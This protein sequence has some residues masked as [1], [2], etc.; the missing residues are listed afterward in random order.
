M[1]WI[2]L[3]WMA[4]IS[5]GVCSVPA[6]GQALPDPTDV[7]PSV[8]LPVVVSHPS[9]EF[10]VG[11]HDFGK[12]SDDDKVT[13]VFPFTNLGGETLIITNVRT[14]CGCTVP[15]LTQKEYAPGQ[16][17]QITVTFNPAG[18]RGQNIKAIHV[19][20]NDPE[21]PV[22]K[23]EISALVEPRIWMEP[24]A[25]QFMQMTKG[26]KAAQQA[27]IYSVDPT[28]KVDFMTTSAPDVLAAK[29]LDRGTTNLRGRK[30][31][32]T[33]VEVELLGATKIGRTH[34]V[35]TIRT[36]DKKK[37]RISLNVMLDVVGDL[38]IRPS[39]VWIGMLHPGDSFEKE[40][41]LSSRSG[42]PFKI[43]TDSIECTGD[44]QIEARI[45]P[46]ETNTP[47]VKAGQDATIQPAGTKRLFGYRIRL[48][49]VAPERVLPMVGT[50][51]LKTDSPDQP[52]FDVPFR[53]TMRLKPRDG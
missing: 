40:F 35:V 1:K 16:S 43:T 18:K 24:Y 9:I 39:R 11:R 19:T 25:L 2:R 3:A 52:N 10:G 17:G 4:G 5:A 32:V 41:V 23:L 48:V 13:T 49:G 37:P 12:I 33:T 53:G 20:T 29:I 42:K 8:E 45:E 44:P 22:V 27:K 47:P 50:L 30:V 28:F 6:M 51:H 38:T 15:E 46:L 14:S 36:S 7:G 31:S 34:E 26:Q 21:H